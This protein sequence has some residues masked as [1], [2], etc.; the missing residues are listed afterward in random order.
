MDIGA[1]R[2]TIHRVTESDMTEQ[3]T[4]SLALSGPQAPH[5]K[6]KGLGLDDFYCLL[7]FFILFFLIL[8]YF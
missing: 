2:A 7:F 3:L 1:W 5:L 4:L 8:F 6:P